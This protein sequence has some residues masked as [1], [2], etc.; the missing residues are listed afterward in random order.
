MAFGETLEQISAKDD[1][2]WSLWAHLA[3]TADGAATFVATEA[4]GTLVGLVGSRQIAG[5]VWLGAM[6]VEPRY[7]RQGI[8]GRLLDAILAWAG[9]QHPT[10][11]VR[12]S[13]V[14][15]QE[16]AVRLYR[17]RGFVF[18]GK[19]SPLPHTPGAVYHEMARPPRSANT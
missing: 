9:A 14:P 3:S 6:W 2:Y 7:R 10:S 19:I 16:A 11:E 18:T 4:D 8:G 17:G 5:F 15:S 13:V 12:L 1:S